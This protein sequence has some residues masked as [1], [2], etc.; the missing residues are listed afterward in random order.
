M[1]IDNPTIQAH[2]EALL[3]LLSTRT[4]NDF[5]AEA[6]LDGESLS[7]AVARY[8]IDYAWTVLGSE[9]LLGETLAVLT[10]QLQTT[11]SAQQSAC[12]AAVLQAAA[13]A[14]PHEALMSFDNDVP[15]QLTGLLW[16]TAGL[17]S[18]QEVDLAHSA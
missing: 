7:Q 8:E 6:R 12:V 3:G 17:G 16:P 14:Q 4:L 11:P 15:L 13:S 10:H 5:A 18:V 9:R 2:A 1:V